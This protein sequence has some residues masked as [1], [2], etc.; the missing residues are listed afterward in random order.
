MEK[1]LGLGC[2]FQVP[3]VLSCVCVCVSDRNSPNPVFRVVSRK[4]GRMAARDEG[5][6]GLGAGER[7]VR[8][9]RRRPKGR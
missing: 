4:L 6:R 3:V 8:L 2:G 5:M 7:E 1:A 9:G